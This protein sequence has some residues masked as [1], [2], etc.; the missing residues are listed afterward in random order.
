M[1]AK[2]TTHPIGRIL[3]AAIASAV[4][5]AGCDLFGLF[6]VSEDEAAEAVV[7]AFGGFLLATL[8]QDFSVSA[9]GRTV[10]ISDY[11]VTSLVNELEQEFS[12]DYDWEQDF[13]TI[14]GTVAFDASVEN[15]ENITEEEWDFELTGGVVEDLNFTL[16]LE[17]DADELDVVANGDDVTVTQD[18]LGGQLEVDDDEIEPAA[19]SLMQS[20]D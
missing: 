8:D 3:A 1:R 16:D 6:S 4:L 10:T 15:P 5:L 17:D 13:E 9:D 18:A 14:S 7:T 20:V 11:D 12:P 2:G 19:Q